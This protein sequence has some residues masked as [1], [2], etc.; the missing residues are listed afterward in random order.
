MKDSEST[1]SFTQ[2]AG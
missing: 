1:C 2:T